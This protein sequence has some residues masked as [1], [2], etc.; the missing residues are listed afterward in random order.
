MYFQEECIPRINKFYADTTSAIRE[1]VP[2]FMG[3][4]DNVG[5]VTYD[6][7]AKPAMIQQ[8]EKWLENV[9]LIE[10]ELRKRLDD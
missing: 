10:D 3:R 4:F 1:L 9:R 8:L 5:N 2:E 6:T 7:D